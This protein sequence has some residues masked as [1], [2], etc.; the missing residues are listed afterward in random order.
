MEENKIYTGFGDKG[1]TRISK[2]MRIPKSDS[3]IELLGCMEEFSA[4]LK[5]CRIKCADSDFAKDMEQVLRDTDALTAELN[6]EAKFVTSDIIASTERLIDRYQSMCASD[7]AENELSAELEQA[8]AILRRGE[9][10][11][12]KVGQFGR[13]Q[14]ALITYINRLGDLMLVF[15][16]YAKA[17][18]ENKAQPVS[19]TAAK[20]AE[21]TAAKT[22]FAQNE[23]GLA[24]AKEIAEACERQAVKTG[25]R[26]VIAVVDKGANLMLLHAMDDSFI[27]SINAA[28]Q[29]AYTS[30]ALRMPTH[31]AYEASKP[32]GAFEGYSNGGDILM[33]GGGY[34]LEANGRIYGAVGIS[35]GTAAEDMQL[36]MFCAEYFKERITG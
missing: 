24:L 36:A 1:Y 12:V 14:S 29:K 11:A 35:G 9:R 31:E 15:S 22:V 16:R 17:P 34:P 8:R 2:N 5:E 3:L 20:S 6:G 19:G 25:K 32:G 33:L 13:I 27:A 10:S 30:A 23:L 7:G 18:R 4:Q 21:L 28:R 26:I